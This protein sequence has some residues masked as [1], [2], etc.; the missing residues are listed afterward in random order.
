[1]HTNY[2][3]KILYPMGCVSTLFWHS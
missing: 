2:I 1:M 3:T